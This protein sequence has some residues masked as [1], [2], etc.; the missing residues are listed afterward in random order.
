MQ[1]WNGLT[2]VPGD[3]GPTVVTIGNFDGV[4]RGHAEV[5]RSVEI[6]TAAKVRTIITVPSAAMAGSI[7]SA[8]PSQI[9]R[10][11]VVT[12]R[13]VTKSATMV[14]SQEVKKAKAAPA[15]TASRRSTWLPTC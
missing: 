8:S 5:L 13:L 9:R 6:A 10:G 11:R 4:H 3:L 2:E 7:L 15:T 12:A 14:S 1:V